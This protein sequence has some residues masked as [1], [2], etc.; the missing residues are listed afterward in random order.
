MSRQKTDVCPI[1]H[2]SSDIEN[3]VDLYSIHCPKCGFYQISGTAY[4]TFGKFTKL[5]NKQISQDGYE[6]IKHIYLARM[7]KINYLI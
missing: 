7:I 4:A 5:H 6:N 3:G 2:I 1:C